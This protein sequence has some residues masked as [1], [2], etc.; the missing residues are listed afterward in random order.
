[1][2]ARSTGLETKRNAMKHNGCIVKQLDKI[3]NALKLHTITIVVAECQECYCTQEFET[4]ASSAAVQLHNM[5]WK[6]AKSGLVCE[7]CALEEN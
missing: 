1:M 6:H 3:Q 7:T 4:D 5:G 2:A